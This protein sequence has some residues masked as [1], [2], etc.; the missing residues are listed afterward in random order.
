MRAE[1]TGLRPNTTYYFRA[2]Y[3]GTE[4]TTQVGPNCSFRTL[5]SGAIDAPVR[6]IVGS[7]MNYNKFIHGLLGKASGPLTATDAGIRDTRCKRSEI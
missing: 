6:F 7:C 4:T 5:P 2:V 3:G 1:L